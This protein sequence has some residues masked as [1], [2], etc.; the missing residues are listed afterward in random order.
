MILTFKI[1][2]QFVGKAVGYF[3]PYG[4]YLCIS[5]MGFLK[6]G[7]PKGMGDVQKSKY[8]GV[9]YLIAFVPVVATF[10]VAFLPTIKSFTLPAIL[11]TMVYAM[12]NGTI[13]ELFWRFTYNRVYEGNIVFAYIIPTIC[14]T[15]WH[16][17]LL[18]AKGVSY[19]GGGLALVGGAGMMGAIWGL[20]MY[21]TKNIKVLVVTHVITNFFAFS[22]LIVQNW[23]S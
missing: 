10:F 3:L 17:A 20:V 11:L 8:N 18:C 12:I 13:E 16:T 6:F 15:C 7:L 4:V 1:C 19:H 2:S 21:K 22:Q 23:F 9:Y 14:F 5:F